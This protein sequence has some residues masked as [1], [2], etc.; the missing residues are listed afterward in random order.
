MKSSFY[1]IFLALCLFVVS[2]QKEVANEAPAMAQGHTMILFMQGD[3]G[4]ESFMDTNL[5]RV[6]TAFPLL[7]EDARVVV[8]YD[9]G[10]Y[11]RLTELYVDD[12][13]TKQKLIREFSSSRSTVDP[14]FVKEVFEIVEEEVP[15]KSY[16]LI[17][18]SHGGGWVPADL[19]DSYILGTASSS[20]H[21]KL[22]F[23]GQDGYECMETPELVDAM[24]GIHFK[25]ILFDA[26]FMASVEALYDLRNSADYII[27]S[28]AEVMAYGFPYEEIVPLLFRADHG[29]EMVCKSFMTHYEGESGTISLVNC[30]GLDGLASAMFDVYGVC[31]DDVD[32]SAI[33]YYDGFPVPLYYDLEQYAEQLTSDSDVL[34]RF[35]NALSKTVI[36]SGYTPMFY[37]G[38]GNA[39]YI[40]LPRSC[41]LTCHVP[42]TGHDATHEAF[43]K[44]EWAKATGAGGER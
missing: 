38:Y 42:Q 1:G 37:S 17:L 7:P 32:V 16:G 22:M 31:D 41:G 30:S 24:S 29:L 3:N 26:C 4:L 27:A 35:R 2:C 40:E 9:R 21:A 18:S 6:L 13:M 44:T 23:Y 14:V 5:Q 20:S 36:F 33:Q 25:Y 11:T 43:L 15:S 10:N 19:F 34:D 8:F 39:G 12:G 28:P